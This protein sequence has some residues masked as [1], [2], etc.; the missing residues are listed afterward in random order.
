M[1]M[2][3]DTDYVIEIYHNGV[4]FEAPIH[5]KD[6]YLK[7]KEFLNQLTGLW[8]APEMLPRPVP[9]PPWDTYMLN[10]EQLAAYSK[11]RR[12]LGSS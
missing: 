1:D 3:D 4:H 10:D 11:F 9:D 6:R 5:G 2:E 12:E 8:H 7:E